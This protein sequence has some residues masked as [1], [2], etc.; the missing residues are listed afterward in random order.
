M[1]GWWVNHDFHGWRGVCVLERDPLTCTPLPFPDVGSLTGGSHVLC[2]TYVSA[3]NVR[4]CYVRGSASVCVRTSLA[5]RFILLF[6]IVCL[7][8]TANIKT[9][10]DSSEWIGG[11]SSGATHFLA[12][13]LTVCNQIIKIVCN[14]IKL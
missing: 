10:V 12:G 13:V 1:A 5:G 14:Q 3:S 8:R 6:K 4:F 11:A 2:G 9:R 7:D